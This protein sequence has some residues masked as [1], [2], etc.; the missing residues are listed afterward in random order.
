MISRRQYSSAARVGS[1]VR[2]FRFFAKLTIC[3]EIS[4]ISQISHLLFVEFGSVYQVGIAAGR[5]APKY[6]SIW[7]VETVTPLVIRDPKKGGP[8]YGVISRFNLPT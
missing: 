8:H 1:F 4:E 6:T 2:W 5:P 3:L 7:G